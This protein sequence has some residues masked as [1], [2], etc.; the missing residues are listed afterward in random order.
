MVIPMLQAA[1]G[2]SGQEPLFCDA[3]LVFH[4]SQ[5]LLAPPSHREAGGKAWDTVK[6][7]Y[8]LFRKLHRVLLV[9]DDAFKVWLPLG[10]AKELS[11]V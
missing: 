9:D 7:L 1:A 6:P 2:E 5:T 4:R 11:I 3:S 10:N 8:K